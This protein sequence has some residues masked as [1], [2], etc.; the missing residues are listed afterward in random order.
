MEKNNSIYI[1][2]E[3]EIKNK[4][5]NCKTEEEKAFYSWLSSITIGGL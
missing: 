4:L 3:E 5:A 2:Y 1:N